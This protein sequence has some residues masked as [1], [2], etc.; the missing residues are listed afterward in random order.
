[1]Q[2]PPPAAD[3]LA[4]AQQLHGRGQIAEAADCLRR[5]VA[6][7]PEAAPQWHS[8]GVM[9]DALGDSE[10]ALRAYSEAVKQ[11]PG[12][13]DAQLNLGVTLAELGRADEAL[14]A[15]E[16][17]AALAPGDAEILQNH[18]LALLDAGKPDAAL[19]VVARAVTCGF[20]P[21]RAAGL[22]G[23]AHARAG[24][25]D[26]A[27][28]AYRQALDIDP[29]LGAAAVGLGIVLQESG[30]MDAAIA[31][32]RAFL[33]RDPGNRA[34]NFALCL[35]LL[36][37]GSPREAWQ[38]YGG[39]A[40][41][42]GRD[43]RYASPRDPRALVRQVVLVER[44]Q[45]IGDELFFLRFVP[46]LRS[47]AQ[48]SRIVYAPSPRLYP[49]LQGAAAIDEL[50]PQVPIYWS[51]PRLLAGDL[52]ALCAAASTA[53]QF[54]G[55]FKLAPEPEKVARWRALLQARG[56]GPYLAVNWQAGSAADSRQDV[57]R[58]GYRLQKRIE[59]AL[60]G[61]ALAGWRGTLVCIQRQPS[62]QD[63]AAFNS[64][65]GQDAVDASTANE[66]IAEL[67]ALISLVDEVVGVSS[68]SLHLR[69][70]AGSTAHVLMP[71]PAEWRWLARGMESPWFPGFPIYRQRADQDWSE[72]LAQL[73]RGLRL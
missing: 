73:R 29:D 69:A 67:L 25:L 3:L 46:L 50:R 62:P 4:Q 8:L 68:T 12:F 15:I 6:L 16:R 2:D 58:G 22:A 23:A 17:A 19:E 38:H 70:G 63:A 13:V 71:Y 27:G 37:N 43:G 60:L 32:Y 72:A 14:A 21:G 28:R 64:A 20:P 1:V 31:V 56:P 7:V 34:V 9:C 55:A 47:I 10:A 61:G 24:R 42:R 51:G 52:P 49:V 53:P 18:A 66:E 65:S 30:D 57:M 59:P 48:P 41:A 44:E 40:S 35:A 11:D 39:R 45:G 33:T 54:P 26:E 5:Y 36:A